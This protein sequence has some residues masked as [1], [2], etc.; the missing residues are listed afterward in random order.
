MLTRSSHAA[1]RYRMISSS[2]WIRGTQQLRSWRIDYTWRRQVCVAAGR[3]ARLNLPWHLPPLQRHLITCAI[4]EREEMEMKKDRII[5][6][7]QFEVEQ[8]EKKMEDMSQEFAEMLKVCALAG[9]ATW[10]HCVLL[11]RPEWR[12]LL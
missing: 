1:R 3:S 6:Q 5:A 11:G 12:V 9:R 2:R 4:V 10:P 7:K 8:L